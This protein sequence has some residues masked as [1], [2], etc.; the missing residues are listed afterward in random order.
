MVSKW[1]KAG[2]LNDLEKLESIFIVIRMNHFCNTERCS[3]TKIKGIR[4]GLRN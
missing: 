2:T 1:K 3:S 4:L